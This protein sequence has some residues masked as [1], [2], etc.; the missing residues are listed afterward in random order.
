MGGTRLPGELKGQT[1]RFGDPEMGGQQGA[2]VVVPALQAGS[3][4]K[5]VW[6]TLHRGE[7]RV[8]AATLSE[9]KGGEESPGLSA[10]L[11]ISQQEILWAKLTRKLLASEPKPHGL[12]G[13]APH[14]P[15]SSRQGRRGHE[16]D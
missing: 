2:T 11:L 1:E 14:R 15:D 3:L 8:L 7:T 13:S 12:Q 4:R 10:C 9:V 5:A 16:G 6:Q